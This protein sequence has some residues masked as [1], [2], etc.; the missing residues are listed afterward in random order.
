MI[1]HNLEEGK[2]R[3]NIDDKCYN[4]L[5]IEVYFLMKKNPTYCYK[6]IG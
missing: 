1:E 4:N 2:A 3:I 5:D 6:L